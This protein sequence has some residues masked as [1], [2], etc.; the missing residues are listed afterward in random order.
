MNVC[1]YLNTVHCFLGLSC[2]AQTKKYSY[3]V[4]VVML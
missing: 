3:Q 1:I 2:I 4:N